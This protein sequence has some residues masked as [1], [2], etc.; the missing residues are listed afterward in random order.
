MVKTI[1]PL[2]TKN[3]NQLVVNAGEIGTLHADPMRLRQVLLNL[4][5]NANKFTE[6]GTITVDAPQ[7]RKT[8]AIGSPSPS[9]TPASA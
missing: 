4:M 9:P 6:R 7:G 8:G 5:S 1:E 2:A 3:A